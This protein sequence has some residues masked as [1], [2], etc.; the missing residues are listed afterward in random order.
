MVSVERLWANFD[1]SEEEPR[2]G[3]ARGSYVSGTR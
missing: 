2:A 3:E 1:T